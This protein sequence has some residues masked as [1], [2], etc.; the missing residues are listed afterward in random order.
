MRDILWLS[1]IF[2][3]QFKVFNKVFELI[4]LFMFPVFLTEKKIEYT[5]I[6]NGVL[7]RSRKQESLIRNRTTLNFVK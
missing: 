3:S 5:R 1:R 7:S 4:I 6:L 2:R